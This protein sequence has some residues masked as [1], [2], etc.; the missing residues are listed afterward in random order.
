VNA[1][2]Q[3]SFRD[4][5]KAAG[6]RIILTGG[7][8]TTTLAG[9]SSFNV[10]LNWQNIGAAPDYKNWNVTFE[11]RNSSNAVVWTGTSSFN[12]RLFL[13]SGS[14]TPFSDNFTLPSTVPQG[15]YGLYLII[16]DPA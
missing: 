9:G 1:T 7:S 5:S 11:L 12:P 10:S 15:T 3:S 16:K 13:P 4:A 14:S 6:Y 8:M 2:I